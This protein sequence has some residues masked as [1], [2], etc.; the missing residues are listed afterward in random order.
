MNTFSHLIDKVKNDDDDTKNTAS[1]SIRLVYQVSSRLAIDIG[2]RYFLK[3][4][5]NVNLKEVEIINLVRDKTDIPVPI[6]VEYW[7]FEGINFILMKKVEGRLLNDIWESLSYEEKKEVANNIS[8]IIRKMREVRD[9]DGVLVHGDLIPL[10]IFINLYD[11]K[12]L[13][14]IDWETANFSN[15][16]RETSIMKDAPSDWYKMIMM[17]L[18]IVHETATEDSFTDSWNCECGY[19][20]MTNVNVCARE[21]CGTV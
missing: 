9:R 4:G 17:T 7:T 15:M 13:A 12:I 3:A 19:N 18:S 5:S 8:I 14:I 21:G 6:I 16:E 10:N 1:K 20:N 2:G 11:L